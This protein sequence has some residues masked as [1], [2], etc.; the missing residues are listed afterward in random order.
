MTIPSTPRR[1][2]GTVVSD[3]MQK[4]RVV[5]VEGLKWHAKYKKSFRVHRRYK[6][7]D[8]QEVTK[9]GDRVRFEECRPLSKD[10]RWRL[11]EKLQADSHQ[12]QA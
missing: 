9:V 2:T 8:E 6:V 5:L 12:P 7:H 1:F 4:T 3:K 11:V 10:K